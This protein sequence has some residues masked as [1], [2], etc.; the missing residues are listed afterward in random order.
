MLQASDDGV[1]YRDVV[2]LDSDD[3]AGTL[4][5][6]RAGHGARFRLVL[7]GGSA[8]EALPPTSPTAC[9]CRPCCAAHDEFRVSEFALRTD[10]R[11]HPAEV[12]AGFGVVPDYYAVDS[13]R[14]RMPAR[15][16]PTR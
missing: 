9:G 6:L 11:V 4:S 12:K 5:E 1:A 14:E 16:R 13:D 7:S 8:A 10:G 3:G 2:R 15:S